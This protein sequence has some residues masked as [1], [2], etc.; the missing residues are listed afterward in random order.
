MFFTSCG[1]FLYFFLLFFL[2]KKTVIKK[3]KNKYMCGVGVFSVFGLAV[4]YRVKN[5]YK[6]KKK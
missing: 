3:T 2:Y 4:F 6:V 1:V 5:K